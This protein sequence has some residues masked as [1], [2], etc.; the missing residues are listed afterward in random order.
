M[1]RAGLAVRVIR[2]VVTFK[3][4]ATD[5]A[6]RKRD[7]DELRRRL[8]SLPPIIPEVLTLDVWFDLGRV[9]SHW[10][11]VLVADYASNEDLEVYQANPEHAKVLAFTTSVTSDRAIIDFEL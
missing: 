7:A 4:A 6:S 3:L 2:H 8:L 10:D 1:E 5:E 9:A 11:A